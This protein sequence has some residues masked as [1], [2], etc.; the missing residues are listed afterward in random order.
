MNEIRQAL[1]DSVP[2]MI[3]ERVNKA[4]EYALKKLGANIK[5]IGKLSADDVRRVEELTRA[6]VDVIAIEREVAQ[7]MDMTVKEVQALFEAAAVE[8]IKS[9]HDAYIARG[10]KPPAFQT[11]DYMR[12]F[13]ESYTARTAGEMKNLSQTTALR[14]WS[15]RQKKFTSLSEGYIDAIDQAVMNTALG[16]ENYQDSMRDTLRHVGDKGLQTVDFASGVSRRLDTVVRA[17]VLEGVRQI[18][19]GI[20]DRIGEEIG[21]DGVEIS[22]H[23]FC[24]PDHSDIQGKQLTKAEFEIWQAAHAYPKRQI[25]HLNCHHFAFSII[26]G[27]SVPNYTQSELDEIKARNAQGITYEGQHYSMYEC[28]QI[29][30]QLETAVRRYSDVKVMAESAGDEKLTAEMQ[31]KIDKMMRKYNDFSAKAN[32]R[33]KSE[34]LNMYGYR[35]T[36]NRN[37]SK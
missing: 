20:Q 6:G 15:E 24:A 4:N 31:G 1:L 27:V 18:N 5:R 26:L 17:N 21:A 8:N 25:G 28:T 29:Q 14:I 33:V 10:I 30:R 22:V 3:A 32:L 35:S 36:K 7:R 11:N 2:E 12:R 16:V 34:R 23:E 19:Q 9:A 37:K 13:V